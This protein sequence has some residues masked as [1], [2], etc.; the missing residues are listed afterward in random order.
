VHVCTCAPG[1]QCLCVYKRLLLF[2]F[3]VALHEVQGDLDD[4]KGAYDGIENALNDMKG[5]RWWQGSH[6]TS[7]LVYASSTVTIG[8][9][10]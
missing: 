7:K 1:C 10:L 3:L 5:S 4:I 8:L 2:T 6:F 9:W